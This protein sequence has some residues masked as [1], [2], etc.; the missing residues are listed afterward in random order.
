[1]NLRNSSVIATLLAAL[2]SAASAQE[3][4]E[5]HI[6]VSGAEAEE[7]FEEPGDYGQPQW[8]ERSRASATTKLYVLSPFEV[9]LGVVSESDFLAHNYFAGDLT[10]EIEIGLPYRFELDLENHLGLTSRL[11]AESEVSVG[12]RYA[13]AAW[14]KIP[15]NPTIAAAYLFGAG[16][17]LAGRF[18]RS[19]AQDQPDE[20]ELRLLLGQEFIPHLQWA[21]NLFFRHELGG[22]LNRQIGFTQDVAWLVI[23]DRLEVG[24]EMR[25]TNATRRGEKRNAANEFVVGPSANW[26]PNL[27]TVLSLAPLFG[28][29]DD[30]PR[31][32]ILASVSLEFGGGESKTVRPGNR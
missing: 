2:I 1:M 12:A 16:K 22:E 19:I 25:Y 9:F 23:A 8:A 10:Q 14:G 17:Q 3:A 11:V 26:K 13:L 31:V 6:V 32:A 20:Y 27:H 28:C 15:L 5:R 29:T 24:A 18:D 21:A 7:E 4:T 30:S